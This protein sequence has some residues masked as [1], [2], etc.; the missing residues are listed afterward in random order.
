MPQLLDDQFTTPPTVE[1]LDQLKQKEIR[2]A[3]KAVIFSTSLG[4]LITCLI[5]IYWYEDP[6]SFD[7]FT[8]DF[9]LLILSWY[10]IAGVILYLICTYWA[11][12]K[13]EQLGKR[14]TLLHFFDPDHINEESILHLFIDSLYSASK[15]NF[16]SKISLIL[17]VGILT[18]LIL[19][20]LLSLTMVVNLFLSLSLQYIFERLNRNSTSILILNIIVNLVYFLLDYYALKNTIET[21]YDNLITTTSTA[22]D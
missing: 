9:V 20:V 10:L 11:A 5:H 1:D 3:L 6:F 22:E 16:L 21:Y 14:I 12:F 8:I 15:S 2:G 13:T 4:W 19:V 7:F 17:I 18:L